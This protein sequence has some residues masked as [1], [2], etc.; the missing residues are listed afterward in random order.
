M[1]T[2][3]LIGCMNIGVNI[4]S[5]IYNIF[6]NNLLVN[7]L[8]SIDKFSLDSIE[9]KN[10]EELNS[11]EISSKDDNLRVGSNKGI[12]TNFLYSYLAG[13]W[14]GDG[15]IY[16]HNN[17]TYAYL[18]ITFN[19]K[20]LTLVNRLKGLLG[21]SIRIKDK[22]N[23]IVLTIADKKN[24]INFVEQINGYL[25]TPKIHKFNL[26]INYLNIR[27]SLNIQKKEIDN[28]NLLSNG[29]FAGFLDADGSF[30]IRYSEELRSDTSNKVIKKGR[31]ELRLTLEQRKIDPKTN[32]EYIDVM[33]TICSSFNVPEEKAVTLRTSFHNEGKEYW[34]IVISSVK[35]LGILVNYL[36][37]YPLLSSKNNDYKDW[38]IVYNM[39]LN[40]EHLT[41]PGK[42]LIK[43]LKDNMNKNRTS[44]YWDHLNNI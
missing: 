9:D 33:K 37:R 13:L 14:E 43:K 29:W 18:A 40:K 30:Q 27:Y 16:I 20:E 7:T 2:N 12:P 26:L 3:F 15:H 31:V 32:I 17:Q 5:L 35:K 6:I 22:E 36:E 1:T 4:C 10:M 23:A 44:F 25:R 34:L 21:G 24:L 38:L 39:I 28:S 19:I 8:S 42:L 11:I 41:I